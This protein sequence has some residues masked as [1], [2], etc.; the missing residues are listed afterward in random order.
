[1]I[2]A[3][4]EQNIIRVK[5]DFSDLNEKM[6]QYSKQQRGSEQIAMRSAAMFRDQYLTPAA[7]ACYW[8]KLFKAWA[9]VSFEP[10][11][12][13]TMRDDLGRVRR[14]SRGV[15]FETFMA[16]LILPVPKK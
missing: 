13:Y 14:R 3:G 7:Q 1:M 5:R 4:A 12:Y 15:P 10:E 9:S 11:L 6:K 16:L 2:E 8:R